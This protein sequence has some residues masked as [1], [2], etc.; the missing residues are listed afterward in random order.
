[1]SGGGQQS[2]TTTTNTIQNSDP[3]PGQQPYIKQALSGA[4]N[5]YENY[6]P[7]YY[8][9]STNAP[10]NE[11][12]GNALSGIY[13]RGIGGSAVDAGAQNLATDTLGGSFLG[14]ENPYFA[15][16]QQSVANKIIPQVM[17]QFEQ[18]GRY[19]S[20]AAAN[21][22]ASALADK[23]GQMA[24]QNYGD[25]RARQMQTMALAPTVSGTDYTNLN[26]ALGAGGQLQGQQQNAI[27]AD[28]ARYNYYQG[29][30]Q[31]SLDNYARVA[32]GSNLG[33]QT[34]ASS[35]TPYYTNPTANALGVGSSLLGMGVGAA[36]LMGG[37]PLG[38]IGMLGGASN[39]VD[40]GSWTF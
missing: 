39:F 6:T 5:L 26:A 25:E 18:S 38:L 33:Q 11:M 20:G 1:M 36:S 16:M 19:G 34:T 40:P 2:G 17:S 8:P 37:N 24:Y 13:N 21:A 31:Q 35:Q 32:L 23:T 27:N 9:N 12:Q 22:L 29:L 7:G 3:W 10:M 15:Q 28:Q 30:P 14:A 4:Q